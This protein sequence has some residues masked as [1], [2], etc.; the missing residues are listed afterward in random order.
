MKVKLMGVMLAVSLALGGAGPALANEPPPPEEEGDLLDSILKSMLLVPAES[1]STEFPYPQLGACLNVVIPPMEPVLNVLPSTLV[2]IIKLVVKVF[3]YPDEIGV[4]LGRLI[5]LIVAEPSL[6]VNL[7][8]VLTG[9]IVKLSICN[10]L[11][12]PTDANCRAIMGTCDITDPVGSFEGC[13]YQV[14][15]IVSLILQGLPIGGLSSLM[16]WVPVILGE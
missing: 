9:G 12:W 7:I 1:L 4:V 14:S 6:I 16:D 11:T 5:P 13:C 10:P 2:G 3:E 15:W 8:E